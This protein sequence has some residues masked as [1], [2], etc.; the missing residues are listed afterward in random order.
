MKSA[1]IIIRTKNEEQWIG[2]CLRAIKAQSYSGTVEII[3][4]DNNSDDKTVEK[5]KSIFPELRV[6][7]IS[8]YFPGDALNQGIREATGDFIVCLS[9]HCI[10][11]NQQWLDELLAPLARNDVGAVYGRQVPTRNSNVLDKR[12]LW[13]TFGLEPRDQIIDPFFHNANSA[14]LKT[15]WR[16]NPFDSEVK[17]IED[18]IWATTLQEQGL[19]I[20]YT[21]TA[22]VYHEHGIHQ[23]ADVE[24]ASG[25]VKI[26]EQLNETRMS[27]YR[28]ELGADSLSLLLILPISRRYGSNDS[29]GLKRNIGQIA[30]LRPKWSILALPSD[31][32]LMEF[33]RSYGIESISSRLENDSNTEDSYLGDNLKHAVAWLDQRNMYFDFI[34]TLDVREKEI[35]IEILNLLS[36]KLWGSGSSSAVAVKNKV[37]S[38]AD[39]VES[40]DRDIKVFFKGNWN[41]GPISENSEMI[42]EAA[43]HLGTLTAPALLRKGIMIGE[44][45]VILRLPRNVSANN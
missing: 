33:C 3:L 23:N 15:T 37:Y 34:A 4:V 9:S 32:E 2:L 16:K 40:A 29:E 44:H 8:R 11:V 41:C 43:P 30:K 24:R 13:L 19:K 27:H 38:V 14:F 6:V 31:R 7:N 12:D 25:V 36:V 17:N 35:D 21:P 10:P 22:V 39:A 1:S 5:A 18:R 42:V 45:P 26:M 28:F 20:H